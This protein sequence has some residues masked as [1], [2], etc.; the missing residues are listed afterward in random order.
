M[1]ISLEDGTYLC[2][3]DPLMPLENLSDDSIKELGIFLQH[4]GDAKDFRPATVD[5]G[6][7]II[8]ISKVTYL[9]FTEEELEAITTALDMATPS[10]AQEV[11]I[12][13]N[14]PP[15]SGGATIHIHANK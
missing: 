14:T 3:P 13:K 10:P 7:L 6:L 4:F 5:G 11:E 1:E 15:P 12:T 2:T 9:R 8:P